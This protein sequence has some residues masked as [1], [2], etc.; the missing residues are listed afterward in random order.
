MKVRGKTLEHFKILD[1]PNGEKLV[2]IKGE[3]LGHFK[4]IDADC[5]WLK[6][7]TKKGSGWVKSEE[8]CGNPVTN[9]S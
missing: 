4:I 6:V 8:L 9:C 2:E 5:N 7:Q 3:S 1:D